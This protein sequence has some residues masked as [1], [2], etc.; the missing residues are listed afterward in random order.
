MPN[1][2]TLFEIGTSKN[3]VK[4]TS[5]SSN[6]ALLCQVSTKVNISYGF[7]FTLSFSVIFAS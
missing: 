2:L 1:F 5:N 3:G 6:S 7:L 4:R